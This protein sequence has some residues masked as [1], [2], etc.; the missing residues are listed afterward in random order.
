MVFL[1]FSKHT[2]HPLPKLYKQ[3]KYFFAIKNKLSKATKLITHKATTITIILQI[4]KQKRP[5]NKLIKLM[6]TLHSN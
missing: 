6:H 1:S 2:N 5:K 4:S 3:E